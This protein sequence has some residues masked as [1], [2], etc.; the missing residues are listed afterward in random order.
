[1]NFKKGYDMRLKSKLEILVKAIKKSNKKNIVKRIYSIAKLGGIYALKNVVIQTA[2]RG[3]INHEGAITSDNNNLYQKQQKELQSFDII[4]RSKIT[5]FIWIPEPNYFLADTLNSVRNQNY[6]NYEIIFLAPKDYEFNEK[7]DLITTSSIISW[8][9]YT[10][11]H[12]VNTINSDYFI[13][14]KAGN[15][16]APYALFYYVHEMD[17]GNSIV[18]SD[19]CIWNFESSSIVRHYLKPKFSKFYFYN[20]LYFGQ[21][22]VFNTKDVIKED[23]FKCKFNNIQDVINEC[24]L[25]LV[26]HNKKVSSIERI[27]LLRNFHYDQDIKVDNV[28]NV[29]LVLQSLKEI[30]IK[31]SSN[32][33]YEGNNYCQ[34]VVMEDFK[35]SIIIPV[36]N[37]ELATLSVNSIIN[38]SK[39]STLDIIIVANDVIF[40]LLNSKFSSL[41]N[42]MVSQIP[43]SFSY[44]NA[45]NKGFN[46]STGEITVF[47]QE[48][49]YF[50]NSDWLNEMLR[51]FSFPFVGGVSPKVLREDNTIKYAG[52]ISGGF[53][54]TPLPFN[55]E[56]NNIIEDFSEPA[57][58]SREISVLSAS[59]FAVRRDIFSQVKGFN[60]IDT[61][62]KF[63]NADISFKI[64]ENGYS[65]IYCATSIIHSCGINWYDN[66]FDKSS[67]TAYIYMLKNW[68]TRLSSDPYFTDTMKLQMLDRIPNDY[69]IYA[70]EGNINNRSS[71]KKKQRNILLVSHELSITGAPVALHY[72]AKALINNGD[73]PVI[74]S[75]YDGNLRQ[76]MVDDGIPVIIDYSVFGDKIWINLAQNF[77]L[78]IVS[79][80]VC[81]GMIKFLEEANIPTLWWA[82]EAK[83]SYEIGALKDTLPESV[84]ENIHVYCGGDYARKVLLSYRPMFNPD[85][86][87]YAIPDYTNDERLVEYNIPDV[88]DKIV[89]SIIGSIMDRKGQDILAKAILEMP[90]HLVKQCKF[91]FIGKNVDAITYKKVLDL[92]NKYPEEVILIDEVSRLELM[93]IYKI[94]D[95][96]ICASRDDPMPVFMTEAMMFSK[97]IICSENTGTAPLIDDGINGFIYKGDD[98]LQLMNKIVYV[99]KHINQLESMKVKSRETYKNNFTMDAFTNHFIE[100]IDSLINNKGI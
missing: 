99:I 75:P 37:E 46:L 76:T 39:C 61:F 13:L 36:S 70:S 96:V 9:E 12:I 51:C 80:L 69:K 94:C 64:A 14:L 19:E 58:I 62:D 45:C 8:E 59:C 40:D 82:H 77:D 25:K 31:V 48:G 30:N 27:L 18:Y 55:G 49:T 32:K 83:A 24:S 68:I 67:N 89:F 1:M 63:S 60:E 90:I 41:E 42:V 97:V 88:E 66:W 20:N 84:K 56:F 100:V 73:Y 35:V 28:K 52:A 57:F 72:A 92:K 71:D 91:I 16:L 15:V 7:H 93:E 50:D 23:S 5:I 17:K 53:D 4:S 95:C 65:C 74:I 87:L 78:V 33:I 29:E 10:F 85:I 54:F 11:N 86:L 3:E 6:D 47:M 2:Q 81:C 38:N 79:T 26:N 43:T 98:Y 21:S 22:V 34:N 44:V